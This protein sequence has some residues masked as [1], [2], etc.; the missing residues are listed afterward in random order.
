M[1][2]NF[3][4]N[5]NRY[6]AIFFGINKYFIP[7]CG[8]TY[9]KGSKAIT[10]TKGLIKDNIYFKIRNL[11]TKT[12]LNSGFTIVRNNKAS[13]K[14]LKKQFELIYYFFFKILFIFSKKIKEGIR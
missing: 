9:R 14:K 3:K 11:K 12:N 4:Y 6:F 5:L 1:K 8:A 13:S 2:R 7:Y 10:F